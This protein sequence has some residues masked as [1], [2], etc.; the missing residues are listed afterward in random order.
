MKN[1]KKYHQNLKNEIEKDPTN[2]GYLEILVNE[3][4]KD[5]YTKIAEKINLNRATEL[6][7]PV[8]RTSVVT[9]V[10]RGK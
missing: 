2:Q 3:E 4:I 10:M 1:R 9:L 5:V 6:G 8:V 7:F